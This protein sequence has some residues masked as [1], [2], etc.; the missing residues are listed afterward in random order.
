MVATRER[1]ELRPQPGPQERFLASPADIVVYG[2]AA[3][4]GKTWGLLMEPLRHVGNQRFGAVI[5]RRTYPRITA[6]GGLWDQSSAIYPYLG[7]RQN[8]VDLEWTFPSGARVKFAHLQHDKDVHN[9]QGSEL[10][11]IGFDEL[12]EFTEHQ[13]WFLLSRNRSTCGVRPYVRATCNPDAD[14]WVAKLIA[15]WIDQDTGFP[16][17]ERAGVLRWFIRLENQLVW[18]DSRE[19][20]AEQYPGIPPKSITFIPASVYDNR[21]LLEKDPGYLANLQALPLVERERFLGGNWKVRPAAGKLFNRA[22]FEVVGAAPAGG[23]ECRFWD[24]A[25]TEKKLAGDDPDYL[26]GVRIRKV[27][28]VYYVLDCVAV[29]VGP[30]EGERIVVNTS[31]QDAEAAKAAGA[32]YRVRWELEPGAASRWNA[33]QLVQKLAGLDARPVRPQGDKV[34]RALA[35]AAQAEAGNVKLVRGAWNEAWLHHMHHQPDLDHDDIMDASSGAFNELA[36]SV[37]VY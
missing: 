5:F 24:L 20:L 3:G 1:I 13:F 29:Q 11:L 12:T 2:G 7:A 19:E 14:S 22:W 16:V 18:S 27:D 15:W 36:R 23:E 31:H 21:V 8:E 30:A 35:L 26:A 9:W 33:R 37:K 10:A 28:G 17:P 25:A 6:Q 32:R 4:G 34:S